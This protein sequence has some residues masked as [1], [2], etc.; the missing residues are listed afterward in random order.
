MKKIFSFTKKKKHPS[1]T[2]DNASAL[3]DGYDNLKDKDLG[4]IHKAALQNDLAKLKQLV[5]KNDVNQLDKENRTALHVACAS[6]HAEAV[7]FLVDSKAKLDLRD[8]QSRS[9]LMKAVQGQHEDIVKILLDNRADPNLA[10]IN[11]NT[12]LH[13]AANIP[14]I[15]TAALLLQHGAE[16]D[17]RNKE[18]FTPL[19]VAVR[20]DRIEMAQFLLKERADVN[21]LD[22]E[23][24]SPLMLAASGGQHGMVKLL[25]Q[26][27]PDVTLQDSK[28]WSAD[29]YAGKNGHHSCGLLITDHGTKRTHGA[30]ASHPGPSKKKRTLGVPSQEVEA[31]FSLGGP[32]I[33]KDFEDNSLSESVS[34]ASKSANDE[35][36]STE[37][38][39]ESLE[40]KTLKVSLGRIFGPKMGEAPALPS[41]SD[42]KSEPERRTSVQRIPPSPTALPPAYLPPVSSLPKSPQAASTPLSGSR[43]EQNSTEDECDNDEEEEQEFNGD[44]EGDTSDEDNQSEDGGELHDGA[45]AAH[46]AEVGKDKKRDFRSEL[47]LEKGEEESSWD[48]ESNS[49]LSNIPHKEEHDLDG[50]HLEETSAVEEPLKEIGG[51]S[52]DDR[53]SLAHEGNALRIKKES[54]KREP[55]SVFSKPK[56]DADIMEELGV[57][58][59]DDLEDGSDWDSASTV[60]KRTLPGRKMPSFGFE[61]FQEDGNPS[62]SAQKEEPALP[63]PSTPQRSLSSGTSQPSTPSKSAPQPQPR[64]SKTILQQPDSQEESDCEQE[65]TRCAQEASP[66]D[67]QLQNVPEPPAVVEPGMAELSLMA[68]HAKGSLD[69]EEQQEK[70]GSTTAAAATVEEQ[71]WRTSWDG[72]DAAGE[73]I[74]GSKKPETALGSLL[75]RADGSHQDQQPVPAQSASR[76]PVQHGC[77][78][79]KQERP[80]VEGALQLEPKVRGARPGRAPQTGKRVNGDPSS[81]FDD[82]SLSDLSDDEARLTT[83]GQQRSKIQTPEE[84]DMADDL[85]ELTQSSDTATDDM[86][87]PTSGYRHASLLIQKLDSSTLDSTSI[88]KLQN[89][90]HEYERSIEKARS[91]HGYLAEKVSQLEVERAALKSSLE[92]VKD[93]KSLLERN[94]LELQTEV[95]NLKF[96]LKQEQENRHNATMMYNTTRDKLRRMEEQHQFEVQERQKVELTL[97]NLELETRTLISNMKQARS[98][99]LPACVCPAC[100][101]F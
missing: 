42:S 65:K 26:F 6:G 20:E 66:P 101:F 18:G 47:G 5:K 16:I 38:E 8:N 41:L 4:K 39:E 81:V 71:K 49:E 54:P 56:E 79:R 11:G 2:A 10:D 27:D 67:N 98:L 24:R 3:S 75:N 82:S 80:A 19:T 87:S 43:Q 31:G 94:Q 28:G 32:A 35:W 60:S 59:V 37:D 68:E 62:G 57:G 17:T 69:S 96:Q 85:D 70:T 76:A 63:P 9:A 34:R 97:R 78:S 51:N 13:L 50:L 93:V 36:H 88:T 15:S 92:E 83:R 72:G 14:S 89:I 100:C 22:Q 99:T 91:R 95:T 52:S 33:D 21:S 45:S 29:D 55:L 77:G 7:Q 58:D 73:K 44:D 30:S 86:D 40:K 25:L 48:S 46:D 1:G 84:M 12:A 53:G 61:E 64:A 23:E 90:F 74:V